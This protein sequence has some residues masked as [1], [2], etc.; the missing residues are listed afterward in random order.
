MM[1]QTEEEPDRSREAIPNEIVLTDILVRLPTKD[2]VRLSCVS[3]QWHRIIGDPS[4]RRLHGADHVATPSE[5]EALLVTK[6]REPGR[7]EEASV[8][9]LSS[10]KA[11]CHVFIPTGYSLTNVCNGFLCFELNHGQAPAVVC[12]PVTGE[13]LELPK[14]PPISGEDRVSLN[15]LFALGFSPNTRE[16]KMFRLSHDHQ[17]HI[18]VHTLGDGTGAW[19]QYS[20]P[21]RFCPVF[22][23]PPKRERTAQMLVLDV[24]AEARRTF[25]L[26]YYYDDYHWNLSEMMASGFDLNGEMCLAVHVFGRGTRRTLQFW[27]MKPPGE[28]QDEDNHEQLCWDLRYSFN[29]DDSYC[30]DRPKGGWLDHAQMLCYR[31]GDT[32]YKHSTRGYSASTSPNVGLSFDQKL[33]LPRAPSLSP[34]VSEDWSSLIWLQAR[35]WNIHGGYRPSL[36]SP[37]IFAALPPQDEK[38][39]ETRQ[40]EH[41]LLSAIRQT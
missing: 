1:G 22:T 27:V 30:I 26:P 28:L 15:H 13:T 17:V 7:R 12:N 25:R 23:S 5:S 34:N 16:Y 8:F 41:A 32:L 37:L 2:V 21:S 40:F 24:A 33:E 29:L 38:G 6:N 10:G 18:A 3:K 20:Y 9:N 36:L 35:R 4:F 11:M 14:A 19:R 31:H 39:E